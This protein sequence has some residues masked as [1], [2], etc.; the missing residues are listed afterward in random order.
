MKASVASTDSSL[1]AGTRGCVTAWMLSHQCSGEPLG[2]TMCDTGPPM[3][4]SAA[5]SSPVGATGLCTCAQD[6][7]AFSLRANSLAPLQGWVVR[8]SCAKGAFKQPASAR[9]LGLHASGTTLGTIWPSLL[10]HRL[11]KHVHR[12]A[13]QLRQPNLQ[14]SITRTGAR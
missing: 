1:C 7:S 13:S 10:A 9:T 5:S 11:C 2:T 8:W 12:Y 6:A 4:A 14:A 3:S